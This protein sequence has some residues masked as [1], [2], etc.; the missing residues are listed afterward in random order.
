MLAWFIFIFTFDLPAW[1]ML[2]Y[3]FAMQLFGGYGSL[4]ETSQGGTAFFA[5]I[6]GFIMGIVLIFLMGTR[7][8]YS[9]R[10]DLSW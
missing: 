10:R 5:H 2:I 1:L 6:G 8:R 3:W 7:E 4:G 9:R